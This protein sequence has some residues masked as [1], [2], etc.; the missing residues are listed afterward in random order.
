MHPS[1]EP[2]AGKPQASTEQRIVSL[3]KLLFRTYAVDHELDS[4][5]LRTVKMP[6]FAQYS[7][8][9]TDW[10]HSADTRAKIQDA[11]QLQDEDFESVFTLLQ[12]PWS[13]AALLAPVWHMLALSGQPPVKHI[14]EFLHVSLTIGWNTNSTAAKA[15]RIQIPTAWK[16]GAPLTNGFLCSL[17]KDQFD[18]MLQTIA[19]N[20]LDALYEQ[21]A[22][23]IGPTVLPA[24]PLPPEQRTRDGNGF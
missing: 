5:Q 21:H 22:L 14:P 15:L 23:P 12:D 13:A 7:T 19:G 6:S 20:G 16:Q 17:L 11:L 18:G 8:S 9:A 3:L 4:E 24:Q 1:E 2:A 10:Y